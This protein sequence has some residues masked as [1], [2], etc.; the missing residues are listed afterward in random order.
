MNFS[1]VVAALHH[2][3]RN[4]LRFSGRDG[5]RL[6]WPYAI[7]LFLGATVVSAAAMIPEMT[8]TM[9]KM[10][11]FAAEHP[12]Q[13]VVKSGPGHYSISIKGSH[14]EMMPDIGLFLI[15]MQIVAGALVVLLA[16]AVA[17]RLHDSDRTALWGLAPLPFLAA[18]MAM[19]PRRLDALE[20]VSTYIPLLL[21][22]NLAYLIAVGSLIAML[23]RKGTDGP[24]RFGDATRD[25]F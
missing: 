11:R 16:A 2:G 9:A 7:A 23:A 18:G 25:P 17:R 6:F 14:P 1:Q 5:R 13:A 19:M 10:Q 3:A 20:T 15:T 21:L 12:D 24:N 8:R 22:N 4:V